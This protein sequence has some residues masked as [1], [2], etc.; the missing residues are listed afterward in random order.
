MIE[1]CKKIKVANSSYAN[2][3]MILN[4]R[5]SSWDMGSL[6]LNALCK[7]E[8]TRS[9]DTSVSEMLVKKRHFGLMSVSR[10]DFKFS[11]RHEYL[12]KYFQS[13]AALF[14]AFSKMLS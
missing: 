14:S 7:I 2:A 6:E 4:K 1:A 11:R 12:K 5:H 8:E 10:L 9:L 13:L 3:A